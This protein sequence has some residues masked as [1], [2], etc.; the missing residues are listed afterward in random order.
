MKM[1]LIHNLH[2]LRCIERLHCG[3]DQPKTQTKYW[4]T[5]SSIRSLAHFAH[6]LARGKVNDWIAIYSV[7]FLFWPIVYSLFMTRKST[8]D[9]VLRAIISRTRM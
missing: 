1:V 7:F 8:Y 9:G 2:C 4:A 5:R 6:S 3:P